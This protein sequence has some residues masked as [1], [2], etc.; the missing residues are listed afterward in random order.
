LSDV[1]DGMFCCG[2]FSDVPS[3]LRR[4]LHRALSPASKK[5][6]KKSLET[7]PDILTIDGHLKNLR[8]E[9]KQLGDR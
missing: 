3:A 8:E 9:L 7:H 2:P 4:S 1:L 6:L 5:D